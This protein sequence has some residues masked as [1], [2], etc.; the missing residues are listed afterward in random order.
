LRQ[1]C[2]PGDC[3]RRQ[4]GIDEKFDVDILA[5]VGARVVNQR[6]QTQLLAG[7]GG[8]EPVRWRVVLGAPD[9]QAGGI[10]IK[11]GFRILQRVS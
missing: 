7:L 6:L 1:V 4:R 2:Q 10:N 8:R 11:M 9:G 5:A 3:H